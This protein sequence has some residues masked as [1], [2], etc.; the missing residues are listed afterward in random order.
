MTTSLP[1]SHTDLLD[2]PGVAVLTT[3]GAD[4]LPQST[5]IW[6]LRDGDSV[7][8]SLDKARQKYKN[9]AARP[10][11]NLFFLDPTNPFRTLEIRAEVTIEPD[12]D[13]TFF[14]RVF[15]HYSA[16]PAM[17]PTTERVVVTLVPKR[18]VTNG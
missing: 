9:L 2:A 1:T 16:D 12:A 6:Y 10:V 4:G 13:L 7:R 8:L 3:I 14:H 17:V 15:Q 11:A 5:A 18:I